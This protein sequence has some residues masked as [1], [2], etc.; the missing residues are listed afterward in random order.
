M[1]ASNLAKKLIRQIIMPEKQS[2]TSGPTNSNIS[3]PDRI[4]A[5]HWSPAVYKLANPARIGQFINVASVVV[6]TTDTYPGGFKAIVNSWTKT[7]GA[8]N[9]AHFLIGR[10]EDDGT[11]QF[12]TMNNNANHAG[13]IKHGWYRRAKDGM[14]LHPNEWSV[15]IEIDNAGRVYASNTSSDFVHKDTGKH[16]NKEDVYTDKVHGH[17]WHK[18]TDYQKTTL[19]N[20]MDDILS[21][22]EK[23]RFKKDQVVIVSNGS[24]KDNLAEW[25]APWRPDVVGHA[26]LDPYNKSDPGPEIMGLLKEW[27]P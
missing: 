2:N 13:G 6:H 23:T 3:M 17:H 1:Q 20:L 26:T 22:A 12:V 10:S 25:A 24:Y 18:I 5:G 27:Y 15:G 4:I 21:R 7:V 8:H 14:L 9:C 16:I 19:R 11:V